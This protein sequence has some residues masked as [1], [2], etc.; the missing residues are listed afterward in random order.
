MCTTG[1]DNNTLITI[2]QFLASYHRSMNHFKG[3][4]LK[5]SGTGRVDLF[6]AG[7]V[8]AGEFTWK[9]LDYVG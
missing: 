3:V 9:L 5:N 1:K 6:S 8:K 2:D 4:A 7:S